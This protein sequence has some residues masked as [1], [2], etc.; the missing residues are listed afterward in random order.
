MQIVSDKG[1]GVGDGF[2]INICYFNKENVSEKPT[3]YNI[4][5]APP[6]IDDNKKY[7]QKSQVSTR[8]VPY[9]ESYVHCNKLVFIYF[10]FF[11]SPING[12]F[13]HKNQ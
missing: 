3:M 10:H 4:E 6:I 2:S 1:T 7:E 13:Q 9:G 8:A 12:R 11:F 5:V